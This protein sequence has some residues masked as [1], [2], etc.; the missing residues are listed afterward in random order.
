MEKTADE[1]GGGRVDRSASSFGQCA[2]CRFSASAGF[3]GSFLTH[4]DVEGRWV[5]LTPGVALPGVHGVPI[6]SLTRCGH[7]HSERKCQNQQHQQHKRRRL[8][9][10]MPCVLL[11][12]YLC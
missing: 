3:F 12:A 4:F 7:T 8:T 10:R 2:K 5:A 1:M 11:C 6:S 9:P